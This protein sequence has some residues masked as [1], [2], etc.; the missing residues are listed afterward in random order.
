MK[1]KKSIKK[2]TKINKN[3]KRSKTIN[4]NRKNRKTIKKNKKNN[5]TDHKLLHIKRSHCTKTK[6]QKG[7]EY[8]GSGG[9]AICVV[10]PPLKCS[11]RPDLAKYMNT[12]FIS[13]L[14]EYRES[15]SS[16]IEMEIKHGETVTKV[17]PQG[18]Y[19][20]PVITS[21]YFTPQKH[22][23]VVYK[24]GNKIDSSDLYYTSS[25]GVDKT[26]ETY[27]TEDPDDQYYDYVSYS[28]S[29]KCTIHKDKIYMNLILRNAG[30]SFKKV[31]NG[32]ES[33]NFTYG[34]IKKN[35]KKVMFHLCHGLMLLHNNHIAHKDVKM[36]NLTIK[37][38]VKGKKAR[39]NFIDFGL[40]ETV[41]ARD[42][43]EYEYLELLG[44]GT[45]VY[46]PPDVRLLSVLIRK[47]IKHN[48]GN[49]S[50]P[51]G[52]L[53]N[54]VTNDNRMRK[55]EKNINAQFHSIG[56]RKGGIV[57]DNY[58]ETRS[59][60]NKDKFYTEKDRNKLYDMILNDIQKGKLDKEYFGPHGHFYKW[61]VYSL[62]LVFA[63]FIKKLGVTD[64]KCISLV[65][66]MINL[67]YRTRF[68]VLQCLNHNYFKGIEETEFV[69]IY[70]NYPIN[71]EQLKKGIHLLENKIKKHHI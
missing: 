45:L 7:G 1:T 4:K 15:R 27:N 70:E 31:F 65:N 68:N 67:N 33:G 69:E 2:I 24:K 6:S 40:S 53:K 28:P 10:T 26:K 47:L 16:T 62:G 22:G 63:K 59:K 41:F 58:P 34:F 8:L 32:G 20:A 39:V 25:N 23:D 46:T 37:Y 3:R 13:K 17:D 50:D 9:F 61:D 43:T 12:K 48:K 14:V 21:C 71:R 29:N 57:L 35:L 30:K 11:E 42:Y 49:I 19:F 18:K 64:S 56:L 60:R 38:N 36:D 52:H 44:G 66:N 55:F 5:S 51:L 54:I